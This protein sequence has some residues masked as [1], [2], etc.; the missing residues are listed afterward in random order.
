MPFD[1]RHD[2]RLV[3]SYRQSLGWSIAEL[4]ERASISEK[5]QLRVEQNSGDPESGTLRATRCFIRVR[6]SSDHEDGVARAMPALV[7]LRGF[8]GAHQRRRPPANRRGR[9][10]RPRTHLTNAPAQR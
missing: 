6:G 8:Q 10:V 7:R 1:L 3:R 2:G 4:A 5:T 9:V